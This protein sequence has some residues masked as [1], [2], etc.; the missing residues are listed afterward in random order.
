[1]STSAM[2]E[3]LTPIWQRVLQLSSVGVED[4]FF[5]VGGD[6]A[7]ALA[8]F[9]EISQAS[10]REIP[11]V[12]IC[13]A[14]TIT[15]LA[16]LL[17]QPTSPRLSPLALLK[18]GTETPPVFIAHGI[19]G[20]VMDFFPLARDIRS[21]HSIYGMQA[22][23]MDGVENPL[24]SIEEMAEFHLDAIRQL[25]PR[26]PYLLIGFSLG[27]LQMLEVAQRL[28]ASGEKVSLLA[29]L[30]SYPH[31]RYLP[32][33]EH[34][35]LMTRLA[36]RRVS[37]WRSVPMREA[38]SGIVRHRENERSQPA[39]GKSFAEAAGKVRGKAE[40]ALA[41]YRPRFYCGKIKFVRAEIPSHFPE[42]PVAVWGHL[43][44]ELDVETVPGDHVAMIATHFEQLGS[45]LS[46]YL[47]E[48][49]S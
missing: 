42:D 37:G 3:M 25:Q 32:F 26:G 35:R 1:M 13:Q 30:D 24:E 39:T 21:P 10:G 7:L 14:P 43:A 8:L 11:P 16:A 28:S 48:A 17:E 20:S 9:K 45:V 38:L 15:A 12:M 2:V 41:R 19:G 34:M 33:G 5:E 18:A 6:S 31:R 40:L 36:R 29:M 22:K 46:R 23:G 27:G 47:A 4:N 49:S 44:S